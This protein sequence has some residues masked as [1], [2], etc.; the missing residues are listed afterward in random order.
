MVATELRGLW[1]STRPVLQGHTG[2][3]RGLFPHC[4]PQTSQAAETCALWASTCLQPQA[5]AAAAAVTA[6]QEAT[7]GSSDAEGTGEQ[8]QEEADAR[9]APLVQWGDCATVVNRAL[10]PP[11]SHK[12]LDKAIYGDIWADLWYGPSANHYQAALANTKKV[13]AHQWEKG[14]QLTKG[15]EAYERAMGNDWADHEAKLAR[16]VCH[17]SWVQ[18]DV[19]QLRLQIED[20]RATLEL[21]GEALKRW[22]RVGQL[23]R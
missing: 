17:P 18:A 12:Q 13:A 2:W 6:A 3:L 22:P 20:A 16:E 23:E 14:M 1:F 15:T 5:A 7:T 8:Q 21:A 9:A 10:Q 11:L 4:Y 19:R